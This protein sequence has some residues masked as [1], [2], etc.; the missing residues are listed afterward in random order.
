MLTSILFLLAHAALPAAPV[1]A[2][3]EDCALLPFSGAVLYDNVYGK[4]DLANYRQLVFC[5]QDDAGWE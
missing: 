3:T 1:D 4:G 2:R 5:G